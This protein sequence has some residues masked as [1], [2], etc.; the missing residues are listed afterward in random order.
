MTAML[1][2]LVTEWDRVKSSKGS[3]TARVDA[4]A[5]WH[6]EHRT[7]VQRLLE[8]LLT[9]LKQRTYRPFAVRKHGIPDTGGRTRYLGIPTL[10]DRE[11]QMPLKLVLEP[12]IEVD[13]CPSS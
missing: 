4:E 13:F 5:R 11:V 7:R 10:R 9:S 3:R 8:E 12:I 2:L 6:L 1:S